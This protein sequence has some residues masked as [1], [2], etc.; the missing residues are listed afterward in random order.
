MGTTDRDARCGTCW[1][2][3]I[4]CPG[5]FGHIALSQPVY[6]PG[7]VTNVLKV[8]RCICSHCGR[9]R[10]STEER[11]VIGLITRAPTRFRKVMDACK[12]KKSCEIDKTTNL[13]C[14]R[15]QPHYSK[16]GLGIIQTDPGGIGNTMDTKGNFRAEDARSLLARIP[17]ED[18]K[19]MGMNPKESR[20]EWM[21]IKVLPVGPPPI[22]PSV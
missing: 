3:A 20:P 11:K 10:L 12:T 22:R 5:H 1:C 15:H 18:I 9:L 16:Q 17:E 14:G 6:H 19:L 21:I 2:D 4:E 7:Y 8:L 13:G